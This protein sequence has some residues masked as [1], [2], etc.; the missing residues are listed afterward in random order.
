M[1]QLRR[2]HLTSHC[3]PMLR[4]DQGQGLSECKFWQRNSVCGDRSDHPDS[5]LKRTL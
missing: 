3:Q 2:I 4:E 5:K 1:R